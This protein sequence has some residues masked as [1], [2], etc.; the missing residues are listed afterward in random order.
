MGGVEEEV[1]AM[2]VVGRTLRAPLG[3]LRLSGE[4]SSLEENDAWSALSREVELDRG[5]ALM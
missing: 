4:R 1:D 2:A 3:G 5:W